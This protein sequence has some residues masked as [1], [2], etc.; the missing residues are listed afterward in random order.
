MTSIGIFLNCRNGLIESH[1]EF[2]DNV[3]NF[4]LNIL[5]LIA[6][7]K[8]GTCGGLLFSVLVSRSRVDCSQPSIFSYHYYSI[9][10]RAEGIAREL[11]ASAKRKACVNRKDVIG[12]DRVVRSELWQGALPG[13]LR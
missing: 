13:V 8:S 10:E 1:L 12:L 2:Q 7:K 6:T 3:E 11:D 5:T 9:V 4:H